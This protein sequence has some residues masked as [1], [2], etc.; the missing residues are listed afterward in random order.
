MAEVSLGGGSTGGSLSGGGS[1]RSFR[2]AMEK[3][4]RIQ[5]TILIRMGNIVSEDEKNKGTYQLDLTGSMCKF[6]YSLDAF[7]DNMVSRCS[8][9]LHYIHYNLN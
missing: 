8:V 4:T 6:E 7:Y 9:L 2:T 5:P 1:V 3:E